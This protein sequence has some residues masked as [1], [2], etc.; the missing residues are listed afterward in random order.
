MIHGGSFA[1]TWKLQCGWRRSKM[2]IREKLEQGDF[3]NNERVVASYI[4]E[5]MSFT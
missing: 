1:P 5:P 3:S 4:L 2:L